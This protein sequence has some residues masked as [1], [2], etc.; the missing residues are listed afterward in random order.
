MHITACVAPEI[1]FW[2]K[3]NAVKISGLANAGGLAELLMQEQS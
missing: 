1:T 2:G 3:L